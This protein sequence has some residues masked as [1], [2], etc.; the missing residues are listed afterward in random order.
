MHDA[1]TIENYQHLNIA[2]HVDKMQ[3]KIRSDVSSVYSDISSLQKIQ[4][5]IDDTNKNT[6]EEIEDAA[7]AIQSSQNIFIKKEE[8]LLDAKE[9]LAEHSVRAPFNGFIAKVGDGVKV[10]DLVSSNTV[11]ATLITWQKIAQI[12]LNEIDVANVKVGQKA[13]LSFDALSDVSIAGQVLEVDVMG[14]ATQ[15]VVSYGVKIAFDTNVEAVKPGM[16]VTA[17]I[18]TEAKQ[19][20]LILS[21]SAVKFQRNS[22]YVELVEADEPLSQQLLA[23]VSGTIL[24]KPPKLQFVEIGISNDLFSEIISGLKEGDIIVTSVVNQT[25]Q[26]QETQGGPGMPRINTGGGSQMRIFH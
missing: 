11:L 6:P 8:A 23:N 25:A 14:T 4:D 10:G 16:S 21:N 9:N 3:P 22:Y 13:T 5:T 2:L 1:I 12:D 20:V 18:I 15:G 17:D 24:P 7:L 26:T 19:D